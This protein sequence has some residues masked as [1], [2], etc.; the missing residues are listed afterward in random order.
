M[1]R[2]QG[3][4]GE[5][6]ETLETACSHIRRGSWAAG[7]TKTMYG[8]VLLGQG[9]LNATIGRATGWAEICRNK[10][11]MAVPRRKRERLIQAV[12]V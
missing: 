5:G 3:K 11:G 12:Y 2:H 6:L 4:G 1:G 10:R 8:Y 9:E 7:N